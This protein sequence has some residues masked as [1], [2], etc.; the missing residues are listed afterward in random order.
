MNYDEQQGIAYATSK[1]YDLLD[2]YN[3]AEAIPKKAIRNL[4]EELEEN[5]EIYF[6]N[7]EEKK[8]EIDTLESEIVKEIFELYA[9]GN[10]ASQVAKIMKD[11]NRYLRDNGKWT[12]T[13][14]QF[15]V[16]YVFK[17][18]FS[19]EAITFDDLCETKSVKSAIYLDMNEKLPDVTAEEKELDK[20]EKKF[21]K[22]EI[23]EGE[24]RTIV[25]SLKDKIAT[26]HDYKFVGKIGNFCPV[27]PGNGGG[28]LVRD[29]NGKFYNVTGS[30]GYRWLE[31]ELVRGVN[32]NCIDRSYYNSLVDAAV[33]TI[34][35]YGDFEWFVSD[36]PVP[37]VKPQPK[38]KPPCGDNKYESC[39]DC[40]KFYLDKFFPRYEYWLIVYAFS[41]RKTR[42]TFVNHKS[43]FN[44]G[45][46]IN[47][48]KQFWRCFCAHVIRFSLL[49][50]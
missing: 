23:S 16:P 15:A 13:G 4:I 12:A 30:T 47:Q 36:D 45:N 42:P 19:K 46:L 41:S 18:L 7:N 35:Q 44:L 37:E 39:F 33:D 6:V 17:T 31:S 38:K 43:L 34:S 20:V 24:Y 28:L 5:L 10:N 26:G 2:A 40:P 21:K 9:N 25:D 49:Y 8:L 48:F 29:Q 3:K 22:G 32:E 1:L 27:L 14:A 11:N 50:F